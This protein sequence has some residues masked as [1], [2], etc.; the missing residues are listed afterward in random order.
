M[1][2]C[3][4][5]SQIHACTLAAKAMHARRQ[6]LAVAIA[7]KSISPHHQLCHHLLP[8]QPAA[9]NRLPFVHDLACWCCIGSRGCGVQMRQASFLH[10]WQGLVRRLSQDSI[11]RTRLLVDPFDELDQFYVRWENNA[12]TGVLGQGPMYL[13]LYDVLWDINPHMLLLLQVCKAGN[14]VNVT[15]C[16]GTGSL[17]QKHLV[18]YSRPYLHRSRAHACILC[19]SNLCK[20]CAESHNRML[21]HMRAGC[22]AGA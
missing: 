16:R 3:A 17:L 9:L 15:C 11:T 5:H 1:S 6:E 19:K 18:W 13:Q 2:S 4:L 21:E 10:R 20:L 7:S 14:T 22:E 12:S 8:P